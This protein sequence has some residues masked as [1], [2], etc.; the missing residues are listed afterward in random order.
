VLKKLTV[1][2][3]SNVGIPR[4]HDD[5]KDVFGFVYRGASF[6]LVSGFVHGLMMARVELVACN[7]QRSQLKTVHISTQAAEA[8]VEAHVK[9]YVVTSA[10]GHDPAGLRETSN[11]MDVDDAGG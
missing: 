4:S 10:G 6:A 7:M 1:Q 9:L 3:L 2:H 8:V 5:F 11:T